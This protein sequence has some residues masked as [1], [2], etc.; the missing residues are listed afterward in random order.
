MG[1][2][3]KKEEKKKLN[4]VYQMLYFL[5]DTKLNFKTVRLVFQFPTYKIFIQIFVGASFYP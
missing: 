5:K 3:G 2:D 1:R 4:D